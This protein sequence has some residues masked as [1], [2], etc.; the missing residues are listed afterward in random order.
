MVRE[1]G[2]AFD[3]H[4]GKG[5]GRV[6]S[7]STPGFQIGRHLIISREWNY[8]IA[9]MESQFYFGISNVNVN[10]ML[11]AAAGSARNLLGRNRAAELRSGAA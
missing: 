2:P 11:F 1:P 4:R 10:V 7:N 9:V 8:G 5:L 3:R 6:V